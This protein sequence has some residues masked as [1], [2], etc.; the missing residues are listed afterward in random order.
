[1]NSGQQTQWK[2][3]LLR[4]ILRAISAH[5]SLKD[6]LIFKGARVLN[7]HL[8]SQRQ[9]LDIDANLRVK[10]QHEM[11]D[12]REQSSWF[13]TQLAMAIRNHFENQELVR[14]EVESIKVSQS[15][16]VVPHPR[17]WD[18]LV[19]KIRVTDQKLRGVRSLPTVEL[20][21]AAPEE[22]GPNAVCEL[23]L[24][25]II[26]HAYALHRIAGEKLRTFLTSLPAYRNKIHSPMCEVRAKDLHDLARIL[27]ARPVGDTKFWMMAAHEFRLACE[28]RYVDCNGPETF[29]QDWATTRAIYESEATL[30]AVSWLDAEQAINTILGI[31]SRNS[32]F[33]LSFPL[34]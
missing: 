11:P 26:I 25:G 16:P 21:I 28:S 9:S 27:E 22:L 17:G 23:P 6:S 18:G 3:D 1:M 19:A 20:E 24:D 7:L 2:D 14:Y 34:I 30:G 13:E 29:Y 31:F 32:V 10:F 4:E 33:P 15:P 5:D 12:R 8:H